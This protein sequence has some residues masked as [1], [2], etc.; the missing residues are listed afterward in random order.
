MS[1]RSPLEAD[2]DE[3]RTLFLQMCVRAESMVR[4][5]VRSVME[6]DAYLG[7]SVQSADSDLDRLEMRIDEVCLHTLATTH[8]V[9][10]ELRMVTTVMKMVTDLERIGDLAVNIARRGLELS[11]GSGYEPGFELTMMG[12][13]AADMV[14]SAADAFLERN[15]ELA[16]DLMR[17]DVQLDQ[18][19][20]EIFETG[21][22]EMAAYSDQ[23]DRVMLTTSISRCLERIGD[24]AVN[25]G[26]MVVF[27]VDGR[28]VRHRRR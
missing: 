3:I 10:E 21:I 25:V 9:G 28:D 8:P 18:I 20:R 16:R 12:E 15:S 5:S 4:L 22:R 26:E 27:L 2:L 7:R 6:R 17:R 13:L 19:N 23:V 11:S 1:V 24:H 14:R